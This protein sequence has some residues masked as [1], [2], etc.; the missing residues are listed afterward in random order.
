MRGRGMLP[1]GERRKAFAGYMGC[2]AEIANPY[3]PAA[4]ENR[5]RS[6]AT[7]SEQ[8]IGGGAV[9]GG[10]AAMGGNP[11]DFSFEQ[12]DAL[13]QFGLRVGAE[14]LGREVRCRISFGTWAIWLF[15][16]HA[17]SC[18]SGLLSIR[19]AVI[20]AVQLVNGTGL[21]GHW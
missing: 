10:L 20:R 11:R 13:V 14:V 4:E 9:R 17:A 15:H 16:C 5:K 6:S 21:G 3:A 8:R 2:Y 18:P 7:L 12:S 19:K 1:A